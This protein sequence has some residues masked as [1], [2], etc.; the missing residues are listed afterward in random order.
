MGLRRGSARAAT[1]NRMGRA[2]W[3]QT[4][5]VGNQTVLENLLAR[6]SA[7]GVGF[8]PTV[9]VLTDIREAWAEL[10]DDLQR[11]DGQ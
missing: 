8:R 7:K 11:E 5:R 10:L 2:V 9:H 1:V 6:V 4:Q 3:L